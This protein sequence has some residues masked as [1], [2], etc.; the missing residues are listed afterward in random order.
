MKEITSLARDLQKN[1]IRLYLDH[2]EEYIELPEDNALWLYDQLE[3]HFGFKK[4]LYNSPRIV[5]NEDGTIT[6]YRDH[7]DGAYG[8]ITLSK[9]KA[10][11]LAFILD[12]WLK[13]VYINSYHWNTAVT[14][15]G[16]KG[17]K[18]EP[19]NEFNIKGLYGDFSSARHIA[20]DLV[21]SGRFTGAR[22]YVC[23]GE[24]GTMARNTPIF[25]TS[26]LEEAEEEDEEP[27]PKTKTL[28][29]F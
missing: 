22:A 29:D 26:E 19:F 7:T 1:V 21:K 20:E 24:Y 8:R 6:V 17:K 9:T 14:V 15:E 13:G 12:Q 3:G 16:G 4:M 27:K 5:E 2:S 23:I 11:E 10:E 28:F 18:D 25:W